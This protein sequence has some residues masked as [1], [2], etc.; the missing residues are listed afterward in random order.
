MNSSEKI[1]LIVLI[2]LPTINGVMA[3]VNNPKSAGVPLNDTLDYNDC[4]Q[5]ADA[6]FSLA[7]GNDNQKTYDSSRYMIDHCAQFNRLDGIGIWSFFGEATGGLQYISD[8]PNR[9]PPYRDWLKKVLY[10]N[11][12]TDYYCADVEA[13]LSSMQ[14]FNAERG[15]DRNGSLAIIKFLRDSHLCLSHY[16]MDPQVWTQTRTDQYNTWRDTSHS[17]HINPLDTTLPT[18]EDLDLQILRGPQ[19]AA[20]KNAFT[21][22]TNKKIEYFTISDNPFK[23]ATTLRFGLSDAE[24]M[25][26][27]IYDV[28]GNK[29]YSD[30]QLFGEGNK[31]WI[32]AGK[33]LPEGVLYARLLTMGGEVK[34]VKLVHEK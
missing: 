4:T 15:L 30:S 19:Y 7:Q 16:Y 14:Y 6:T 33:S 25:K 23:E 28:L 22:A 18:L 21:P 3:Q 13:I 17:G 2:I 10:Y 11:M 29:V 27:E 32:I 8:D 1:F 9:W 24:Y 5:K 34:T 20:V 31:E 26:I 12:D